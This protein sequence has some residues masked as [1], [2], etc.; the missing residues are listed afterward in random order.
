MV[1]GP[2]IIWLLGPIDLFWGGSLNPVL[3]YNSI[4]APCTDRILHIILYCGLSGTHYTPSVSGSLYLI[5]VHSG[6]QILCMIIIS[7]LHVCMYV[8]TCLCVCIH[9]HI[10]K[11]EKFYAVLQRIIHVDVHVY[12]YLLC[13]CFLSSP[14]QL[15]LCRYSEK[16]QTCNITI[17]VWNNFSSLVKS[18][19]LKFQVNFAILPHVVVKYYTLCS[20]TPNKYFAH[21][22]MS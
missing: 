11:R 10:K 15:S 18:D 1:N 21:V 20:Y 8:Y 4:T 12:M 16:L 17:H 3:Q 5:N 2:H 7:Q 9:V 22:Q 19:I 6:F 14:A 13:E